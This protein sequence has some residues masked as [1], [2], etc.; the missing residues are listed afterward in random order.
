LGPSSPFRLELKTQRGSQADTAFASFRVFERAGD[1]WTLVA[2]PSVLAKIGEQAR[3]V[4]SGPTTYE[5]RFTIK[6]A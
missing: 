4:V 1:A 6:S 3:M 5:L 2:A